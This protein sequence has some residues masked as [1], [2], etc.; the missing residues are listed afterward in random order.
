MQFYQTT[1]GHR[2]HTFWGS[3]KL[4]CWLQKCVPCPEKRSSTSKIWTWLIY[5]FQHLFIG[6]IFIYLISFTCAGCWWFETHTQ[7][8]SY[9]CYSCCFLLE[10]S[11]FA[12]GFVSKYLKCPRMSYHDIVAMCPLVLPGS[13]YRIMRQHKQEGQPTFVCVKRPEGNPQA[14]IVPVASKAYTLCFTWDY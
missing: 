13:M 9:S 2:W 12:S 5:I 6:H 10:F 1:Q 11:F 3:I 14:V 7:V 4:E 8:I